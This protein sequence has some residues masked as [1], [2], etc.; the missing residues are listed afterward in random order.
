MAL[1]MARELGALAVLAEHD[2]DSGVRATACQ[3]L[4]RAAAPDDAATYA[5][6]SQV[7]GHDPSAEVRAS[8]A[9]NIREDAP[10]VVRRGLKHWMRDGSVDVERAAVEAA[11]AT[12]ESPAAFLNRMRSEPVHRVQYALMLLRNNGVTV[13]WRDM[14]RTVRLD[15]RRHPSDPLEERPRLRGAT[16]PSWRPRLTRCGRRGAYGR[17]P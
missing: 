2:P 4:A 7:A 10:E 5:V 3:A 11:L 17:R 12:S 8:V 13:E 9:A 16:H 15:S 6:L 1:I 14:G